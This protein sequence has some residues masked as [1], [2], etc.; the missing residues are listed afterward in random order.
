MSSC[1]TTSCFTAPATDAEQHKRV[2]VTTL[3][4]LSAS[5]SSPAIADAR[6]H[7]VELSLV[8]AFPEGCHNSDPSPNWF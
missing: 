7:S 5:S 2:R 6:E 8:S 4:G 1:N 3:T